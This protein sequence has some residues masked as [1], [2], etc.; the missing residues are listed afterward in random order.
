[1]IILKKKYTI[2][3][4]FMEIQKLKIIKKRMKQLLKD[5]NYMKILKI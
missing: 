1:M 4:M 5:L 3:K 2:L